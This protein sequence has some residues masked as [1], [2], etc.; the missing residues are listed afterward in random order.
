MLQRA[1]LGKLDLAGIAQLSHTAGSQSRVHLRLCQTHR[2]TEEQVGCTCALEVTVVA[3][4]RKPHTFPSAP[5]LFPGA[6]A[7]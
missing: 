2:E 6:V 4:R 3:W 7:S 1:L 5:P